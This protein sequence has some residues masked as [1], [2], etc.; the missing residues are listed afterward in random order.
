MQI[1]TT[2][3]SAC[4]AALWTQA[5]PLLLFF[6][7][8]NRSRCRALAG[9]SLEAGRNQPQ[10]LPGCP[11]PLVTPSPLHGC[12]QDP[13]LSRSAARYILLLAPALLAQATFEVFKR[14]GRAMQGW[15]AAALGCAPLN[16]SLAKGSLSQSRPSPPWRRRYLMAQGVVRPASFVTL[17]GL[18]LSPA[19][20]YCFVFWLDWR[21]DGAA[22]GMSVTQV[23]RGWGLRRS[24]QCGW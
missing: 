22:I 6:R 10:L 12:R 11:Q 8:A 17:A 20:A 21:L 14:C 15:R 3:L 1:L 13:L 4:V 16:P 5:E 7:Q 18:A 9:S 19:Y 2:L 23:W 24:R